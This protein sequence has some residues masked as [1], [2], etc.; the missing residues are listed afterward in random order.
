MLFWLNECSEGGKFNIHSI[1][2]F[3]KLEKLI[4]FFS[5]ILNQIIIIN[6]ITPTNEINEPKEDKKFHLEK[7]SG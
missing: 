1:D 5:S 6:I 7:K 2:E 4:I 3:I